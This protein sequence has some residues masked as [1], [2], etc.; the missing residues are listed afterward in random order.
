MRIR[1]YT[2]LVVLTLALGAL[3]APR[4]PSA[5]QSQEPSL[6]RSCSAGEVVVSDGFDRFRCVR[7]SELL[8]LRGCSDGDLVTSDGSG[9]LRCGR[10]NACYR[11]GVV[12]IDDFGHAG[13]VHR[14]SESI[15]PGVLPECAEGARLISRGG[16]RWACASR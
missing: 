15:D 2:L 8:R 3:L 16:G 6:P 14:E 13:C 10:P 7:P 12:T 1:G 5:A 9:G 4:A 11:G